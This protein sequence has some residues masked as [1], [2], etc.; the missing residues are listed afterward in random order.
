MRL[1]DYG[2]QAEGK[3]GRNRGKGERKGRCRLS[4]ARDPSAALT[5]SRTDAV[6]VISALGGGKATKPDAPSLAV[7]AAATRVFESHH[8]I[9]HS[10]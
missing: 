6:H 4:E 5:F 7:H 8:P 2:D 1:G 9:M 10:S 3:V